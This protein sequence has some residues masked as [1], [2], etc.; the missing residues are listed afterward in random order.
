MTIKFI[1]LTLVFSGISLFSIETYGQQSGMSASEHKR[2]DSLQEVNKKIQHQQRVKDA[3]TIN[4][5]KKESKETEANDQVAK[6]NAKDAAE[7]SRQS[8][9][10]LKAEKKAQK[11]RMQADK[12]AQKASDARVKSD[13]NN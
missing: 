10:S 1:I 5:A 3:N 13:N 7:A 4:E 8:K 2:M 6:R 9:K 11:S 12:Q